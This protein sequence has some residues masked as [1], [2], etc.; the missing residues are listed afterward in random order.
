M[1]GSPVPDARMQLRSE[2]LLARLRERIACDGSISFMEYMQ[3]ALYEPGLGYYVAGLSK[4]G[5]SGDFVTAAELSPLFARCVARQARQ[6]LDC[7]GGGDVLEFGAGSGAL[8]VDMLLE[9]EALESLPDRY[10]ILEVS[11]DLR[12][13]QRELLTE[14]VPR[15]LDRIQWIDRWPERFSGFA[16]GNEV[17]DAMPVERFRW[18]RGKLQQARVEL[19]EGAPVE[20]FAPAGAGLT[21]DVERIRLQ[22]D[23]GWPEK[24]TSEINRLLIPWFDSFEQATESAALILIDYGY[25]GSAYYHPSRTDGT[26]RCHYRHRAHDDPYQHPGLQDIT[27]HVD[28]SAV[29]E[30]GTRAGLVLEGY[31]S[32]QHFLFNCDLAELVES[33]MANA[34]QVGRLNLSRQVQQLTLPGQMGETFNVIGFSKNIPDSN[35]GSGCN[36][37]RGFSANDQSHRL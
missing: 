13:S 37:L 36:P 32:Q 4:F 35:H 1:S 5:E 28:F 16:F 11:P 14:K 21:A 30:A 19:R 22:R 23:D 2:Q 29:A 31:T 18:R 8:A 24:F 34:D 27:A 26:L 3:L 6:V 33:A 15:L 9:L 10:S 20:I 17:L 7:L 25:P 12:Q